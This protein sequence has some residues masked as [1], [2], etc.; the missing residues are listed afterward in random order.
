MYLIHIGYSHQS[1]NEVYRSRRHV[2]TKWREG[3]FAHC[4]ADVLFLQ[5]RHSNFEDYC[6]FSIIMTEFFSL[7]L[8]V[9][10]D[11]LG[12]WLDLKSVVLL[13][14]AVCN[15][16][17][18]GKLIHLLSSK[19]L[20]HQNPVVLRGPNMLHWLCSRSF[21]VADVLF[22]AETKQSLFLV[23]YLASF[24]HSVRCVRFR[25][26]CNEMEMMY[27]VAGC[28]RNL[29]VVRLQDVSLSYA[30][31]ALLLSNPNVQEIWVHYATCKLEGLM[32]DLSLHKLQ[33]LSVQGTDCLK[34]FPWSERTHSNSLQRVAR[35]YST[36]HIADMNSLM[37]NCAN[38]R[39]LSCAEIW[40]GDGNIKLYFRGGLQLVNLSISGNGAVTD[41]GVLFLAQNLARLRTFNIQKCKKLTVQSLAHIAE[42]ARQLEVLYCDIKVPGEATESAVKEFS[43]KCTNVTYL[44]I[45]C[46]FI[47]CTTTC[48]LSLLEGCP[49][50]RTLVVNKFENILPT[51]RKLCAMMRP[52]LRILVHDET[53]EYNVL[54]MP[55]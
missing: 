28:S 29:A 21:K 7:P 9:F 16:S 15:R 12:S 55:I 34:G 46:D 43:R 26:K 13:D 49:A 40:F 27:L 25:G 39:S 37:H 38:I 22:S 4:S 30:F 8:Q 19:G 54:T 42:H 24:G 35:V 36:F 33:L 53:T 52:Q 3:C 17:A 2:P 41:D 48:T 10:C 14:S 50:L 6:K 23:K 5:P 32:D 11:I 20:V 1:L 45:N 18:R 47:L 31:H 44:N 51:S